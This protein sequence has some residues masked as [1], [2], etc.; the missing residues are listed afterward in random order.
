MK[1]QIRSRYRKEGLK[2][3]EEL[4][5][6]IKDFNAGKMDSETFKTKV[7]N[8]RKTVENARKDLH[9]EIKNASSN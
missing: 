2:K 3:Q 5:N 8:I 7:E 9:K 1:N 6:V 4:L